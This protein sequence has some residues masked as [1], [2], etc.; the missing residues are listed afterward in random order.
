M[1]LFS[2]ASFSRALVQLMAER[3]WT[4]KDLANASG[5]SQPSVSRY[6]KE[7]TEPKVSDLISLARAFGVTL[8]VVAGVHTVSGS[9]HLVA[10]AT[11]WQGR[12]E[13]AERKVTRLKKMLQ[14]ALA[15]L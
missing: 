9:A 6:L 8:D 14:E 7:S 4:Q 1:D 13:H 15:E 10:S 2:S 3:G 12:A 5:I 11:Q